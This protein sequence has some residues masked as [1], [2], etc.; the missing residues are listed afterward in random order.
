[1]EAYFD[2]FLRLQTSVV[3]LYSTAANFRERQLWVFKT[4]IMPLNI[5][6]NKAFSA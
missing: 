6:Q 5:P 2:E 1:M 3:A 4:S